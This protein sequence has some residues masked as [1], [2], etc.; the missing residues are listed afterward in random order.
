[1]K[2]P[3]KVIAK[4]A[5]NTQMLA[6]SDSS[7]NEKQ[8]DLEELGALHE[9]EKKNRRK[10]QE[11][12]KRKSEKEESKRK[13]AKEE[14]R[15]NE[16]EKGNI[17]ISYSHKDQAYI[18]ELIKY[19][20]NEGL[21]VWI[22]D[23]INHSD[24]W[25]R[26]II[27]NIRECSAMVVVMTPESEDTDWVER[28]YFYANKINKPLFPLLLKGECFPF[29]INQQYHDVRDGS[30]PPNKFIVSLKKLAEQRKDD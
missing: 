4:H 26:T 27:A 10:Q 1:M 19:F 3:G 22:D 11:E 2:N 12:L 28:E 7:S 25:W 5:K 17:F 21:T 15:K 16:A 14:R 24:R 29:F 20:E 9:V 6:D 23:R 13:K 18:I 30:M 8:H